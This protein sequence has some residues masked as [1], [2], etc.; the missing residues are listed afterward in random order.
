M[1]AKVKT[2]SRCDQEVICSINLHGGD[3]GCRANNVRRVTQIQTHILVFKSTLGVVARY[4]F[5]LGLTT[6]LAILSFYTSY[7]INIYERKLLVPYQ[8]PS[9]LSQRGCAVWWNTV[10]LNHC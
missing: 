3:L 9:L 2:D 1:L 5:I 8:D 7:I 10:T 6:R 4:L